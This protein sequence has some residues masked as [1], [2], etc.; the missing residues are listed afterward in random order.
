VV[1][2]IVFRSY[3]SMM[4]D[5]PFPAARHGET[6]LGFSGGLFDVRVARRSSGNVADI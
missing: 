3:Q 2:L 6:E 1:S 4:V 5:A